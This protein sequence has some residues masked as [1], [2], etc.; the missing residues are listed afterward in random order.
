[1]SKLSYTIPD[2]LDEEIEEL[3]LLIK[4]FSSG[5]ITEGE[6]K[7]RR[8]P[9]GIYEQRRRGTYM[10]RIRCAAGVITPSQLRGVSLIALKYASG[11]LHVT[12]RQEIQIHDVVLDDLI[13]IVRELRSIGLS[14]R[15]GGGNTVRNVIAPWNAGI[16]SGE[17]F[18]VTPYAVALT[19]A[20]TKRSD[21]WLLP[22]KYKIAL[23][24]SDKDAV[25]ALINDLGFIAKIKNG[26]KGFQVFVAGG[27]GRKSATGHLLHD[28]VKADDI[29]IVTEAIK[30]VFSKYGN[31][32]NKHAARLRFLWKTLGKDNFIQSYLQE[33]EQLLSEGIGK[34]SV[35]SFSYEPKRVLSENSSSKSKGYELWKSRHVG[36]QKQN[37]YYSVRIPL[38]H[39]MIHAEKA[40][41]LADYLI[42]FGESVI[43]FSGD[44]NI[45]LRHMPQSQLETIYRLSRRVSSLT[46]TA[47]LAG[48]S[49]ACA[50]AST[51][52]L[53]ICRSR[54]ALSE[55]M[56][57]L[58]SG[59]ADI[60]SVADVKMHLSGCSN[61]CGQHVIADL[62][63]Y[64][65]VGR[66]G[67]HSYPVYAIVGG[68]EVTENNSLK[69][70]EKIDEISAHDLPELVE[71]IIADYSTKKQK[72]DTFATY[73]K[74]EG[75][76]LIRHK[77]DKLGDIPPF[78]ENKA[79]YRDWGDTEI[80]SLAGKGNGECSAGLFD[81]IDID[82]EKIK[83]LR[84]K[85]EKDD[86]VKP[87]DLYTLAL[88]SSRMLLI[89]KGVEAFNESDVFA[90][91]KEHFID[92]D[93]IE[94]KFSTVVKAGRESKIDDFTNLK[95]NVFDLSEAVEKLYEG[96]D[97]SLQFKTPVQE[98]EQLSQ[99]NDNSSTDL[100]KDFRGVACPM[101]FVKTKLALSA[102]KSGQILSVLLD[103]GSPIENVPRSVSAEGH[104][105]V[106]QQKLDNYWKVVIKK[107]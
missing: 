106:D 77:C 30:R 3:E 93:L 70:A 39:G 62:G 15:G 83:Q 89:T 79:Y 56:E 19:S 45:M 65:K 61:S 103:E 60:D 53:G 46:D 48:N 31:R 18:D 25:S 12:T 74:S 104:E 107:K 51:C 82:L 9:F 14:T 100:Q 97:N 69:L 58:Q 40:K 57:W 95:Q 22:R 44:Q 8:V 26:E 49:I 55:V 33:R 27:M 94:V 98:N 52:Q 34:L 21:S 87:L 43:R 50:G 96:M 4:K 81:L 64:G 13:A 72:Y 17:V 76:D 54:A 11:L 68:T 91:F 84:L 28:F 63:F 2:S 99:K 105:I 66:N 86:A 101:N 80:F 85:I 102:L 92:E 36:A 35:Q 42:P 10:V 41:K 32:K 37:W 47:V 29:V 23:V 6:L 1:M 73:L 67:Q 90:R 16:D 7:A 75:N 71:E 88:L 59:D 20:I 5:D 38:K 78:S 24:G